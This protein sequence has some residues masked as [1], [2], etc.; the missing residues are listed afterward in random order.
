MKSVGIDNTN[1]YSRIAY[2]LLVAYDDLIYSKATFGFLDTAQKS[3]NQD[4][5]FPFKADK[6]ENL[7]ADM[8]EYQMIVDLNPSKVT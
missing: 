1:I 2:Q 6:V 5:V 8:E 4:V 7:P 3:F